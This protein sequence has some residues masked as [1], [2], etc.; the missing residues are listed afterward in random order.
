MVVGARVLD[1][2]AYLSRAT[3]EVCLGNMM[4]QCHSWHREWLGCLFNQE[5]GPSG[6][7]RVVGGLCWLSSVIEQL[8]SKN[9]ETD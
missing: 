4:Y 9:L 6:A 7:G 3:E 2:V 1:S 8:Q 5:V